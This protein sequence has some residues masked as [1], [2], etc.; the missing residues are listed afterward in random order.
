MMKLEQLG[1]DRVRMSGTRGTLPPA[2]LK[3]AINCPGG[4]RNTMTFVLTGLDI[5]QKAA[6][7][8]QLLFEILGGRDRFAEVDAQLLRFD[9]ADAPSNPQATAHLR[10]TVK[11]S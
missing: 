11:D 7:A 1:P 6:W 3:V 5:E 9:Q 10:I 4:Y 8:Q 2:D